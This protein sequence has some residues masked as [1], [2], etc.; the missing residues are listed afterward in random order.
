MDLEPNSLFLP[1]YASHLTLCLLK[2]VNDPLVSTPKD[3]LQFLREITGRA[4]EV[5][6]I[7][8]KNLF[9]K[10][11]SSTSIED[12]NPVNVKDGGGR[13]RSKEEATVSTSSSPAS[14]VGER[15]C[16]ASVNNIFLPESDKKANVEH[17]QCEKAPHGLLHP[18][19]Q[20]LFPQWQA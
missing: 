13:L 17:L 19:Q 7:V 9:P 15:L 2:E 12:S 6:E 8:C 4:Q 1:M 20:G 14:N 3:E 11:L 18:G 10:A 5:T 16:S